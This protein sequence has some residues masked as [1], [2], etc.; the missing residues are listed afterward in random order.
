MGKSSA[1]PSYTGAEIVV[2]ALEREG[3]EVVFGYPGGAILDVFDKLNQTKKFRFVL[4]RHEQGAGHAADGYARSSG[5]V[6]VVIVTSGPGATNT[7]TALAT[8]HMDSAPIVVITGQVATA[9]IGNDAFQEA[10]VVGITRPVTKHN[11][12]VKRIEDLP[13]TLKQAFY[14]ARSG[15]PGPVVVDLPKDVQ[16]AALPGY[17]YPDTV[18]IRSYKPVREGNIAQIKKAA[19]A[20]QRAKRPV[21][22]VG[23]GA[24]SSE[25][26]KE[27]VELAERCDIPVTTTLLGLG[28][29]PETHD[30]A[31][32]MLGM[33]GTEYANFAMHETDLIIAVGARFDD[34]VTGALDRFAPRREGV[35]HIDIDP[36]SISKSI[37]ATIPVVGDC[38]SVLRELLKHLKPAKRPEWV[39]QVLDLKAARPL[40][41]ANDGKL[42]PQYVIDRLYHLT[43]GEAI[44]V[45]DVGQNQM[46]SAHYYHYTRPRQFLSSGGLG[47]MGYGFPAAIGAQLANPDQTVVCIAGDG[48]IQMNIQEMATASIENVPVKVMILNNSYLGMVRQWQQHFYKRNY[49]GVFLHRRLPDGGFE[50]VPDFVKLCEAYGTLG[51]CVTKREDV[52]EA[53]RT[54]LRTPKCVFVDFHVEQEENVWPMIP[55]GQSFKEIMTGDEDPQHGLA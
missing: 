37:E 32:H 8:A 17:Q 43:K 46:W 54:A 14:I 51:I 45:A 41:F 39:K 40:R 31:L 27:L 38:R 29:F 53:I 23:Q 21:L 1:K 28:A 26:Q 12:L 42:H 34:R 48:G 36:S 55:A 47:T 30:L 44:I 19:A 11:F 13:V 52:D 24:V 35:I 33:H 50:Y 9:A 6:G 2:D 10:D 20:I 25:C 18:E 4:T 3:V 7:V 5:K 22:Y 15:R 49:S 16:K